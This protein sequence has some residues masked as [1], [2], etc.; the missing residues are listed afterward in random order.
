MA[1]HEKDLTIKKLEERLSIK[2]PS[3]KKKL[4]ERRS[5]DSFKMVKKT[6]NQQNAKGVSIEL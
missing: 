3:S 5:M 2:S 4:K 1:L 6:S